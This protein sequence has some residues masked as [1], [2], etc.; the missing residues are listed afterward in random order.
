MIRGTPSPLGGND[1][2]LVS[3]QTVGPAGPQAPGSAQTPATPSEVAQQTLQQAAPPP[4]SSPKLNA[5][6][7][8][9]KNLRSPKDP[10][11]VALKH[12]FENKYSEIKQKQTDLEHS[13]KRQKTVLALLEKTNLG[14]EE[15]ER[16]D[17]EKTRLPLIIDGKTSDIKSLREEIVKLAPSFKKANDLRSQGPTFGNAG[18]LASSLARL[19]K[20]QDADKEH[21][22]G[23]VKPGTF[24]DILELHVEGTA[25][26]KN[27]IAEISEEKDSAIHAV[28]SEYNAA[29]NNLEATMRQLNMNLPE[30]KAIKKQLEKERDELL[31]KL[32]HPPWRIRL[33]KTLASIFHWK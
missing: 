30:I 13:K 24:S 20:A 15:R 3:G 25:D 27:K 14:Q 33:S 21:L 2:A 9:W 19:K 4:Q 7:E 26:S 10:E 22:R 8:K 29:L 18:K 12:K 11:V 1:P 6:K 32:E 31:G 28:V 16:L 5:L 17:R 23:Q